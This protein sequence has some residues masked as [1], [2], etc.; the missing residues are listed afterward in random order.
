M[1]EKQIEVLLIKFGV[2]GTKINKKRGK[3]KKVIDIKPKIS[4]S[5]AS[6]RDKGTPIRS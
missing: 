3:I 1:K 5:C 6:H 4:W 2:L